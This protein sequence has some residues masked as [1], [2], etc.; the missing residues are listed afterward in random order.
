MKWPMNDVPSS[1]FMAKYIAT[2][3]HTRVCKPPRQSLRRIK[4]SIVG[5]CFV[6]VR[7]V[8]RLFRFMWLS[9]SRGIIFDQIKFMPAPV[10][11]RQTSTCMAVVKIPYDI[12]SLYVVLDVRA[13]SVGAQA[14]S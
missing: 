14:N 9:Q 3:N 6:A 10:S 13:L 1:I 5:D 11:R 8:G 12:Q 2:P 7:K 4:P